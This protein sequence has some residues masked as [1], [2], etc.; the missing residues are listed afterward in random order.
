MAIL[1]KIQFGL[2]LATSLAII[3]TALGWFLN[4][5]K[6]K[7]N[8][9]KIGIADNTKMVVVDNINNAINS[10]SIEFNKIIRSII[11]KE[12][13]ID[14]QLSRGEE[15]YIP[16]IRSKKIDSD[17][18]VNNFLSNLELV[19]E[20][21]E[22]ASTLRYTILPSLY[23][24]GNQEESVRILKEELD[25]LIDI[26]SESKKC[27]VMFYNEFSQVSGLISDIT[28][29]NPEYDNDKI[30]ELIDDKYEGNIL[31]II[32]DKNYLFYFDFM[33]PEGMLDKYKEIMEM[34]AKEYSVTSDENKRLF[35][36]VYYT[37]LKYI[38]NHPE[39]SQ[40]VY[41]SELSKQML[42]LRK[43]CKE[44]LVF[45]S[46]ISA[47]MQQR[48]EDSDINK[49]YKDLSS[50]TYLSTEEEIR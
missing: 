30:V 1:N 48:S 23:T 20:F 43:R 41:L 14:R 7:I 4:R 42:S 32:K 5:R 45:I 16:A 34:N 10:M 37:F 12:F 49:I 36:M 40:A 21:Y 29:Q 33:I 11:D 39:K 2:D 26:Y 9:R 25:D 31:S 44:L 19:R 35:S 3:G 38:V 24:I 18:I 8:E 46:S 47:K 13:D 27:H 22:K 15:Y 50:S 6:E 28:L 17:D